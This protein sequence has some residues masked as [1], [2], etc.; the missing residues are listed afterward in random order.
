MAR[1][2]HLPFCDD[3]ILKALWAEFP[4]KARKKV[5]EMYA[6]LILRAASD[7]PPSKVKKETSNE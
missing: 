2:I 5:I 1:Q 3:A 7:P 6:Q 4:E